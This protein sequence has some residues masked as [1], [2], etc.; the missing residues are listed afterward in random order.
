MGD[1][2]KRPK[3]AYQSVTLNNVGIRSAEHGTAQSTGLGAPE[4]M[5]EADQ[6][7]DLRCKISRKCSRLD[8]QIR[9]LDLRAV[10][11]PKKAPA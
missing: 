3:R 8:T 9:L 7:L 10:R 6:E 5:P 1:K 11:I 4:A 2:I